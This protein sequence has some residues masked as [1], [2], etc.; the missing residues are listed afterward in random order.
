MRSVALVED[1]DHAAATHLLRADGHEDLCFA[2]WRPS[3][4]ALRTTA[5]VQRLL[6]PLE[7]ERLVHGNVS[8]TPEYF[9]RG[10]AEAVHEGAGLMLMH[11]HP[12]GRGWQG[13]SDDDIA[14]EEGHAAAVAGAT[15][16]PFVGM[17][18]AGD[19]T[20][21][22][23]FWE[24]TEPRTYPGYWCSTVRVVGDALRVSFNPR[25]LP[26]P[27]VNPR[28]VRT[29]SA[30][31]DH[32]QRDLVRLRFGLVGAG[33]V[34]GLIGEALARMGMQHIRLFDFDM[35]EELNLDR[36]SYATRRDIG[37][38]KVPL[39]A[40]RLRD[41]ATADNFVVEEVEGAVFEPDAFA[42]ALDCDVLFACVDKPWG[43]YALNLIASAHLI[44]VIDGGIAARQNKLG[45]LAAADWRA[46]VAGPGH[47]CLECLGQYDPAAVQLEREGRLDDP[48][49]I[50]GLPD[51]HPLKA[52]E[53]VFAFS[54]SCASFQLMQM[55]SMVIDPLGRAN[56][57]GQ[58]YHFV[59][60][61]LEPPDFSSCRD[62][63]IFPGIS[64]KGDHVPFSV[65]GERARAATLA[66]RLSEAIGKPSGQA[67]SDNQIAEK[68]DVR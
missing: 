38:A 17:T 68:D 11:S 63:C 5:I 30:W 32:A 44:P 19:R 7:G 8:F 52:R 21:S 33:S 20:W 42:K 43:R 35:V 51:G 60:G 47:A 62:D 13:M 41:I 2:L 4:G 39:L 61:N 56:I 37:K 28:T 59:G 53:N 1:L 12:L 46:H 27:T 57:G 15:D 10:I 54:M 67:P 48:H 66:D 34:G 58:L 36:L 18:L 40:A 3:T 49:Y 64:G 45:E 24:R 6:L 14:A 23:R 31:G 9:E 22:A 65:T 55:L 25:L 26:P 50:A 29:V 16:L